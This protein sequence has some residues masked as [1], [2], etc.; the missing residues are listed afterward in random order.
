M[1]DL[2]KDVL[3]TINKSGYQ[4]Y[5]V[6]GFVRDMIWKISSHDV[7]ICTDAPANVLLKLFNQYN[8]KIFK[9]DTIKFKLMDYR[10]DIARIREEKIVNNELSVTFQDDLSIDYLRRD[11]TFNALYLDVNN[12]IISFENSLEDCL[13]KKIEFIGDSN[14]RIEEDGSRLLRYI[15]FILKYDLEYK[16]VNFNKDKFKEFMF[17]SENRV[18]VDSIINR[19]MKLRNE[20]KLN[21]ILK[22]LN[23]VDIFYNY[24]S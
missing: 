1:D 11:F 18:L 20:D 22:D 7:D 2:V 23:I 19:M 17:S 15:S 14:L 8:P 10:F 3:E 4:A 6:G 13:N 24:K 21:M 12:E 5:I 9:Y 16:A